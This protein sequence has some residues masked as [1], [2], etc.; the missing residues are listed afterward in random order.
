LHPGSVRPSL[1]PD[2]RAFFREAAPAGF[3]LFR[4]NIEQPAQLRALTDDL[5]DL[6]GR[7]DLPILIDQE[8]GRIARLG[9]AALALL[10]PAPWR[11][12]E[13]Y[14]VAPISAMEAARVNALATALLLREMG[15]TINCAPVL[16][17]RHAGC[18][19]WSVSGR[20]GVIPFRSRR[21]GGWC[22]TGWPK[23]ASPG[24]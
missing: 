17:L 12:A 20:S 15:I 8:G 1:T 2:E 19:R 24:S 16:D 4:R 21:W 18:H 14:A 13:L 11:F 3:I 23:A 22:S 7:A 10:S 6:T 5:R 9:A